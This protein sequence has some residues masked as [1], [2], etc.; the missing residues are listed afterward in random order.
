MAESSG[1]LHYAFV[2]GVLGS[3]RLEILT[4]LSWPSSQKFLMSQ[5]ISEGMSCL[6]AGCGAGAITGHL[7]GLL[8]EGG[9]VT[10]FDM[11]AES[12]ELA[13]KK[14][15][16]IRGLDFK[17]LD[18]EADE[19]AFNQSFDL[20]YCRLILEHL[21][22]PEAAIQKLTRYLKPGGLFVAQ[23]I[24]CEGQYC[25]PDN[26]AYQKS[27]GLLGQIID[28]RGGHSDCGRW[29][30]SIVRKQKFL[31]INVEVENL[32]YLEGEGKQFVPLTME[33]LGKGLLEEGLLEKDEFRELLNDLRRFCNEPDS[34]VSLPR[35]VHCAGRKPC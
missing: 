20:V 25:W 8:G 24:D 23:T 17:V 27:A 5:G 12:I 11:D 35:F 13:R 7:R 34:V 15:A 16:G 2:H 28:V 30:P 6:E 19:L 14:F 4:R 3:S 22:D 33:A 10:G 18:L 26:A 32:V 29:L 21:P 31:R 9:F 1:G